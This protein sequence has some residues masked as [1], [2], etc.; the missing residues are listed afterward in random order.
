RRFVTPNKGTRKPDTKT[1]RI[2]ENLLRRRTD[3]FDS[4][5]SFDVAD[6]AVFA[7]FAVHVRAHSLAYRFH[8]GDDVIGAFA[9]QR[10]TRLTL[11]FIERA[12][13]TG[14]LDARSLGHVG[15][16]SA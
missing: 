12:D 7:F 11:E 1:A 16:A 4:L 15:H 3:D 6:E 5:G 10:G 13:Q 14:V 9:L 2:S 8:L